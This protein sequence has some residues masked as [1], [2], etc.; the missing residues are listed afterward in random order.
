MNKRGILM[1]E[2]LKMILAVGGIVVLLILATQLFTLI[3]GKS[4]INQAREHMDKIE[5]IIDRLEKEGS[6]SDE[7]ILLSPKNWVLTG[8]PSLGYRTK[9]TGVGTSSGAYIPVSEESLVG[10]MPNECNG[11]EWD[12]CICYCEK[13]QG[14]DFLEW[15]DGLSVCIESSFEDVIVKPDTNGNKRLDG[16]L[17]VGTGIEV[18]FEL[19]DGVLTIK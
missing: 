7:Y 8:W 4:D 18:N 14:A 12:K 6:G 19:D 5:K 1:K 11:N 13:G 9:P 15:C 3:G 16:Y 10:K 2:V 17:E